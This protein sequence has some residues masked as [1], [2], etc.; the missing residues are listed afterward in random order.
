MTC[1][2]WETSISPPSKGTWFGDLESWESVAIQPKYKHPNS[3]LWWFT[4]HDAGFVA[5]MM[6]FLYIPCFSYF[7][8][9]VTKH[10]D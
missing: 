8:I 10:H 6:L 1:I 2:L 4:Q 9:A 3:C 7:S 5:V